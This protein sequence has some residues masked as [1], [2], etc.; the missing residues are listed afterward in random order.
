MDYAL[1]LYNSGTLPASLSG[2][3]LV[4]DDGSYIATIEEYAA[5]PDSYSVSSEAVTSD[6]FPLTVGNC[7]EL[8]CEMKR[9]TD[10]YGEQ[11]VELGSPITWTSDTGISGEG[12][13]PTG[14]IEQ[15]VAANNKTTCE[16]LNSTYSDYSIA[17]YP[18]SCLGI[19]PF[20]ELLTTNINLI[21]TFGPI[22]IDYSKECPICTED[23]IFSG[24][25]SLQMLDICREPDPSLYSL[26]VGEI[27]YVSLADCGQCTFAG[28]NIYDITDANPYD[29]DLKISEW[30]VPI[31][32]DRP[33]N[34][35]YVNKDT[36]TLWFPA[37]YGNLAVPIISGVWYDT[38]V[39]GS[40]DIFKIT[41]Q[42][43]PEKMRQWVCAN[44]RFA[45][46]NGSG[47]SA[48]LTYNWPYNDL[49]W[50]YCSAS[51]DVPI[52]LVPC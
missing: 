37:R 28:L 11:Y 34:E 40:Q 43:S 52:N 14:I 35:E 41:T 1:G 15:V 48:V 49:Y 51:T 2:G 38:S 19:I 16:L 17:W 24:T 10:Y 50:S 31:D 8:E 23:T 9:I 44:L 47:G 18:G 21:D 32:I 36:F 39:Y 33:C 42:N 30:G 25:L 5:D 27:E 3:W 4:Y 20:S 26:N 12:C 46:K 6:G 7:G 22:C 13:G 29:T 45:S